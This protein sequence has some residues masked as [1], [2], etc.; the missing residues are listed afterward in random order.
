MTLMPALPK[1]DRRVLNL[2]APL[3]P[4]A[5]RPDWLRTWQAELWHLH[6]RANRRRRPATLVPD[7]YIGLTR[8][9]LWLRT[10]ACRTALEGT[11]T[12]CLASLLAC[13]VV[14]TLAG[15][16]LAG[17]RQAL[18]AYLSGPL[19]RS[20][21]AAVIVTVVALATSS[22]RHTRP[23][24]APEPFIWLRRQLFFAAKILTTLVTVFF[25]S[26]DLCLPI[27]P[28]LPNTAD[29]LQV[30]SFVLLAL[31]GIRWAVHDQQH[32]CKRC[33]HIL[34]TP[35][36]VGRP[37]HNLLEWNG[38]ELTCKHGH[39]LLSVPEMETSWCSTS[40]WIET[41]AS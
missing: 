19:N 13:T 7:H 40:Q 30:L 18:L 5:D 25:L 41:L 21:V 14:A 17:S 9:A 35:A 6:N 16:I 29:L 39:G 28:L 34:A 37:S 24:A 32:R 31:V 8:D 23:D 36:R 27:H 1:P 10:D 3:V 11:P 4:A 15:L 26:A 20:L 12:L 38:T 2:V 33:L 22:T